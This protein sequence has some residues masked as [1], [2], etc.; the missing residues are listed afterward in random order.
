MNTTLSDL[1]G[2]LQSGDFVT[3]FERYMPPEMLAQLPPEQKSMIEQQLA[4]GPPPGAQQDIQMMVIVLQGMQTQTP[5]FNEAGDRATYQI[6]DPTGRNT[7]TKPL[8]MRKIDGKW[9][10]DPDTMKGL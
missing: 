9:Y 5:T 10:V 3:A 1:V 2:L 6:S 4:A 7:D 8:S